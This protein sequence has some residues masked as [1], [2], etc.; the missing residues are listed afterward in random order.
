M[1]TWLHANPV[2]REYGIVP[3]IEDYI[4]ELSQSNSKVELRF[5]TLAPSCLGL[6]A[7]RFMHLGLTQLEESRSVRM[8]G[9]AIGRVAEMAADSLAEIKNTDEF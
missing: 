1:L 2:G 9:A 6:I 7:S 5:C 8:M 4:A 3:I